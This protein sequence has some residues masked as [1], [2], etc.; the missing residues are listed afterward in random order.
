MKKIAKTGIVLLI[1]AVTVVALIGCPATS[2]PKKL[3]SD[4]LLRAITV[5]GVSATLGNPSMDWEETIIPG[6]IG[7][8]YLER[9]GLKNAAVQVEASSGAFVFFAQSKASVEPWFDKGNTF[10]FDA[11]DYLFVEVFSENHDAYNVYAVMIHN[12]NPGI[13][14]FTLGGRSLVGG[15]EL[16]GRPI[17]QFGDLGM[18]GTS[19]DA[20]AADGEAWF[21]DN[22]AGTD[23][24]V[25]IRPEILSLSVKVATTADAVTAPDFEE[26]AYTADPVSGIITGINIAPQAGEYIYVQVKGDEESELTY[27]KFKLVSKS[28]NRTIANP[29]F[30][31]WDGASKVGEY[32]V[33]LGIMGTESWSGGE[34]YGS[35][36][37]GAEIQGGGGDVQ[38]VDVN[39]TSIVSLYLDAEMDTDDLRGVTG[40]DPLDSF[41]GQRPPA[42]FHVEFAADYNGTMLLSTPDKNQRSSPEFTITDGDFGNLVGFWWWGVEVTSEIGERGWYKFATRIGSQKADILDSLTVNGVSVDFTGI[43]PG[44]AS[45]HLDAANDFNYA[46]VT[47]PANTDF[48]SPLQVVAKA[49][50]GYQPLIASVMGP[51]AITNVPNISFVLNQDECFDRQT[52]INTSALLLEPG[53]FIYIRVTAEV[54]HYYGG[55]G[56]VSATWAPNRDITDPANRYA[57]QRFYKVQVLKDGTDDG[58]E[59]DDIKY[60]GVAKTAPVANAKVTVTTNA[61]ALT[62]TADMKG[63][64]VVG[65]TV[66][67]TWSSQSDNDIV[68]DDFTNPVFDTVLASGSAKA[69]SAFALSTTGTGTLAADQFLTPARFQNEA[70]PQTNTWFTARLTSESGINTNYYRFRLV[71]TE[72]NVTVPADIKINNVSVTAVGAGNTAAN[73]TTVIEHELPNKVAFDSVT[74]AV[75]KPHANA[76]VSFGLANAN[77]A[78]PAEYTIAPDGTMTYEYV[79]VAQ[80]VVIRIVSADRTATSYF[81]VRLLLAGASDVTSISDITVRGESIGTLPAA[82]A[83]ANGTTSVTYTI[84][85]DVT[86]FN[87][88]QVTAAATDSGATVMYASANANDAAPSDYTNATGLF[89]IWQNNQYL[90][91]RVRAENNIDTAYY[92]VQI[93]YQDPDE[94]PVDMGKWT[95]DS[96]A[97]VWDASEDPAINTDPLLAQYAGYN[98]KLE[99]PSNFDM[100]NYTRWTIKGNKY[101]ADMTEITGGNGLGTAIFFTD[102]DV[103]SALASPDQT[104]PPRVITQYNTASGT[105]YN[106][107][108]TLTPEGLRMEKNDAANTGVA[109]I[110]VTEVRFHN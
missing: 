89:P 99:L 58:A 101:D 43:V 4:A 18:P 16:T 80:F 10:D 108:G 105:A 31:I 14:D 53:N 47:L 36:N 64:Y 110:K 37:N 73:G 102:W 13:M 6:N 97:L 86:V 66:T 84:I 44:Y 83:A 87:N 11:E 107:A 55:S 24:A 65:C 42:G 51:D 96:G 34:A 30:I 95:L 40:T 104:N 50:A 79:N 72:G 68:I 9:A 98:I 109:F 21:G 20:V 28:T 82:N 48:N 38:T 12:R 61:S 59:L 23:L 93:T 39:S 46:T 75:T 41:I 56:F 62:G 91:I 17:P 8:V 71:N 94:I 88:L 19:W 67:N 100:S 3:S 45:A 85:G 60:K 35:Y 32:P 25:T 5:N 90:V 26:N 63:N 29:R 52:G 2:D 57:C 7:H 33:S 81:K 1:A 103:Q 49:P 76:E 69:K 54:S 78:A 106:T 70:S 74:L 15:V 92:K 27:Y 77:N 22:Q